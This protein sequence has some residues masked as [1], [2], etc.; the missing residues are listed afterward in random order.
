MGPE[1]ENLA[2]D[3]HVVGTLDLVPVATP[4]SALFLV[5]GFRL[6]TQRMVPINVAVLDLNSLSVSI[7][8]RQSQRL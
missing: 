3:V 1:G 7:C 8:K 2:V 6:G 5:G 4:G